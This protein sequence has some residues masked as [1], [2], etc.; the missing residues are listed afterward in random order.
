[1]PK[2]EYTLTDVAGVR[3]Y[4]TADGKRYQAM[5]RDIHKI[6]R[7][8]GGFPTKAAARDHKR[9]MEGAKVEGRDTTISDITLAEFWDRWWPIHRDSGI[10]NDHIQGTEIRW[11]LNIEP[12]L[13]HRRMVDIRPLDVKGV[14]NTMNKATRQSGA[15][16]YGESAMKKTRSL[17]SQ[18]FYAAIDDRIP[19]LTLNPAARVKIPKRQRD[20][21]GV[22]NALSVAQVD[23]LIDVAPARY[24]PLIR[25]LAYAGLRP[26]EA[27]NATRADL[28]LATG[29]LTVGA[30][31]RATKTY[32]T[33]TIKLQ[34][35]ILDEIRGRARSMLPTA[36][37]WPVSEWEFWYWLCEKKKGR[38]G[39][40]LAGLPAS[41]TPYTLRH[42]CAT[43]LADAGVKPHV[44]A[45][46]MGH[47]PVEF[48]RTY[49]EVFEDRVTDAA[50]A[51]A[52]AR[53][54]ASKA[55]RPHVIA[56]NSE[57]VVTK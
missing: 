50:D 30:E 28:D 40:A 2:I 41:T 26:I 27:R 23:R 34:P 4:M 31:G 5:W 55:S 46:F 57:F 13:G 7:E 22:V 3:S 48:L 18:L 17:I 53:G 35:D 14:I 20:E 11:R 6:K 24:K 44:A 9:K 47:N 45:R 51:I 12:K 21:A 1:M 49:A 8:K 36:P 42:T 38:N 19:G 56:S 29:L 10:S 33:R 54:V 39:V 37:L 15:P 16:A 52:D 25:T 32:K 43:I